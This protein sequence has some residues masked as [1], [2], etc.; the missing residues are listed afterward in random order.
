MRESRYRHLS[1]IPG[2]CIFCLASLASDGFNIH[3]ESASGRVFPDKGMVTAV[4]DGDTI[5]VRFQD[6]R[7]RKVRLIGVDSPEI[8]DD[9]E[10]VR[11][12]GYAAK[13][14]SFH[15]L[16]RQPVR[17]TYDW[18]HEDKYGRLLAYVWLE[19]HFLFNE[20]IIREG[21][22]SAFMKFPFDENFMRRFKKA[23]STARKQGRGF[24]QEMPLPV[25]PASRA[26]NNIG[27]YIT[28]IFVCT[29]VRFRRKF[30]FLHSPENFCALIDRRSLPHFPD[31]RAMQGKTLSVSGYLEEY[32]GEPQIVVF[33]PLQMEVK[34]RIDW[35]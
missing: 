6:G 29:D 26:E 10:E 31:A 9:R 23:E 34:R 33:V 18:E 30:V 16:Y 35:I 32:R 3:K 22:A 7:E 4:Y 17:L 12:M 8:G 25:I 14:F 21:Y 11:M 2:L 27:A 5:K 20:F 28:I 15:R 13:R 24:W 1:I 19:K